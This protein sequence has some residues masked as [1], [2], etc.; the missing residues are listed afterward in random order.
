MTG[1]STRKATGFGAMGG[2]VLLCGVGLLM[3]AAERGVISRVRFT[4]I[5][6]FSPF[7][8]IMVGR[9]N[10]IVSCITQ[11]MPR[12][13][14]DIRVNEKIVLVYWEITLI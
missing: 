7:G 11:K 3:L 10:S 14:E 1:G 9:R 8:N 5:E 4:R 6:W 12:L 13:C 2:F